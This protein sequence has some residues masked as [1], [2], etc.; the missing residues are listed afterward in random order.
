MTLPDERIGLG[1]PCLKP[2]QVL[3]TSAVNRNFIWLFTFALVAVFVAPTLQLLRVVDDCSVEYFLGSWTSIVGVIPLTC[4]AGHVAHVTLG[5][6]HKY[7]VLLCLLVPTVLLLVVADILVWKV[8]TKADELFSTDCDTFA[9]KRDL[10][11]ARYA[12]ERMYQTCLVDTLTWASASKSNLT[13]AQAMQLYRIGDC[14]EYE[15]EFRRHESHWQYLSWLEDKYQCAGWCEFT[16]PLW[17]RKEVQDSCSVAVSSVF[18]EKIVYMSSQ[19]VM[20]TIIA[21]TI[22]CSVLLAVRKQ[23]S[24]AELDNM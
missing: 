2:K 11:D 5:R 14:E 12:A 15:F 21:M 8:S 4:L 20:Y 17:T 7:I 9:A 3:L 18:S 19:V 1:P 13:L 22:V 24:Q 6:L 23:M 10:D 16:A